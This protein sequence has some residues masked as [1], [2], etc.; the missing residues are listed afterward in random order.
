MRKMA[1]DIEPDLSDHIAN[2]ALR[3]KVEGEGVSVRK[4]RGRK[5]G[6][7]GRRCTR[8]CCYRVPSLLASTNPW[9]G[10]RGDGG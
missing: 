7:Q 2:G 4:E 10:R 8:S 1:L 5:I 3:E 9:I 6:V